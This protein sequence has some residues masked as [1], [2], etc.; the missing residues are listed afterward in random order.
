[1]ERNKDQSRWRYIYALGYD[2]LTPLY[3]PIVRWT[4]REV[5]FK[6][7]LIRQAG[8]SPSL[9]ALDLGCGTGTLTLGI[10]NRLTEGSVA[11]LDGDR[12]ILEMARKKASETGA[13]VL[14]LCGLTHD[15]PFADTVFDRVFSSFLFHH[16]TR[17]H[18]RRA[19]GEV[20]RVLR[21]G[22]EFHLADWGKP[23]NPAL[24]LAFLVIQLL[25]GFETT[26]D[27]VEGSMGNL[28]KETGFEGVKET[29]KYTTLWG[30]LVFYRAI[31]SR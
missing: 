3:D 23:K 15:L 7:A 9:R 22:G 5:A 12:K 31:K 11:G 16:L 13:K 2:R 18:K 14:W 19:L 24:R 1:M 28:L 29:R 26:K 6:R 21:K 4:T 30:T 8:L 17:E 25:D 10:K 27:H 20:F